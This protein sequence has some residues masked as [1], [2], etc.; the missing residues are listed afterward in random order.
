MCDKG[1]GTP[2]NDLCF[3]KKSLAYK[4]LNSVVTRSATTALFPF[5]WYLTLEMVPL[6]LFSDFTPA[7][8]WFNLTQRLAVKTEH[9]DIQNTVQNC[10]GRGS[11]KP[12]SPTKITQ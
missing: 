3:F 5:P 8:E 12:H 1:V 6:A 2:W 7:H 11:G 10:F 9:G 4:V